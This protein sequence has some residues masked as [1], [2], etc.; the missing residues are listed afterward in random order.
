S[1]RMFGVSMFHQIH[2]LQMIRKALINGSRCHSGHCL[3]F[4]RQAVLCNADTT[5]DPFFVDPDG[6]MTGTDGLGMT[7]VCRNWA[8]VYAYTVENQ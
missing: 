3:N 6:T 8:Q 7:T 2:C 5:L 1:G 4:L